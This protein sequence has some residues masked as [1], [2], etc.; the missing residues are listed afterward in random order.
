[1]SIHPSHAD[2]RIV[3][4]HRTTISREFQRNRRQR[5]FFSGRWSPQLKT[6]DRP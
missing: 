4:V 6:T 2:G 5:I 3:G 1:M